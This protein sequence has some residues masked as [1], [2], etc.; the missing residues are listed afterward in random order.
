MSALGHKQ[1][2]RKVKAMSTIPPKTDILRG[3]LNGR[4][5]PQADIPTELIVTQT[6]PV[7]AATARARILSDQVSF[8]FGATWW[9]P[10][11][12]VAI[13]SCDTPTA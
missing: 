7:T 9:E 3:E 1:T 4:F 2:F 12:S 10:H 8:Q 11:R 5:V 6:T 13:S